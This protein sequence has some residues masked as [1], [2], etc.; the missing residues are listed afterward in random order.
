MWLVCKVKSKL[1]RVV[2]E[3][4]GEV[5]VSRVTFLFQLRQLWLGTCFLG[6][7]QDSVVGIYMKSVLAFRIQSRSIATEEE[8]RKFDVIG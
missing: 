7:I 2:T 6:K 8:K 3:Y 5:S 1:S 4:E